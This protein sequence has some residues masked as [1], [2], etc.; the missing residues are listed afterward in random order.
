MHRA[1][2]TVAAGVLLAVL[3]AASGCGGPTLRLRLNPELGATYDFTTTVDTTAQQTVMGQE[4]NSTQTM[5]T[6]QEARFE[7]AEDGES[8]VASTTYKSTSIEVKGTAGDLDVDLGGDGSMSDPMEAVSAALVGQSFTMTIAP[9]GRVTELSGLDDMTDSILASVDLPEAMKTMLRESLQQMFGDTAMQSMM[10]QAFVALPSHDI[11]VGESWTADATVIGIL[12]RTTM[13]LVAVEDGIATITVAG[14]MQVD[15]DAGAPGGMPFV[16]YDALSGSQT[17]TYQL[18][19]ATGMLLRA[20]ITS[21]ST[22]TMRFA[23]PG[24]A[25][26][27]AD[28]MPPIPIVTTSTVTVEVNERE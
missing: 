25:D 26:E 2:A 8:L 14:S 7:R 5:R 24:V 10:S 15:P 20:D 19:V 18:E 21:D 6:V 27:I 9:N 16:S 11:A 17:G 22:A 4:V 13:T 12:T 28:Q 23:V 1:R 3:L